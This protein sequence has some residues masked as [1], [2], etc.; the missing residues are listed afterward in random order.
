MAE[1]EFTTNNPLA[2]ERW[3]LSLAKEAAKK[4]YFIRFM[5]TGENCI[6]TIKSEL[7]K[8][9]GDKITV[10]LI[11][12]MNGDGAE[13]DNKIEGTSAEEALVT[14]SDRLNIDQRRKGTKS[15]GKASE[16]RV[17]FNMRKLG[18][19]KL[20]EWF[21]EDY[22]EQLFMYLSGARGID[23]GFH[24]P[25]EWTGRANNT[26]QAPDSSHLIYGGDAT[27]ASEIV[28]EDK[29]TLAIVDR[30]VTQAE[31]TD[32]MIQPIK[33]E[34]ENHHV[35]CMH[36]FQAHDLRDS[37]STNDWMDI[38]KA[39]NVRGVK[40]PIFT[41]KLGIHN[42]VVLHKHRNVIRFDSTVTGYTVPC[43]RALFMGAQAG[44][45]AWGGAVKGVRRY[46]WNE[47]T[48]DRGNQLAITAGAI[49][50]TKKTRF[51]NADFGVIAVD[52]AGS[53]PNS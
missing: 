51:N 5:G 14:H 9:R 31:T 17:L 35:L 38:Q 43:A 16:Q 10:P 30:L 4:Q 26:L 22:D 1:T 25:L 33:I 23:T 6:I 37:A 40:N 39:A 18:R 34:G 49:Y 29:M 15:K 48:D 41:G 53:N 24:I 36:T 32:P 21:A 20:A 2:V 44:M 47:E 7:E 46:D 27:G 11:M 28:A 8:Q 3:S 52:T 42:N 13:G 50:G 19:E 45:I 12:K